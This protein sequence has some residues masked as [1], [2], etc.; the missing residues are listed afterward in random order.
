MKIKII[1]I[2]TWLTVNVICYY[3]LPNKV[4]FNNK[5]MIFTVAIKSS[6]SLV[7]YALFPSLVGWFLF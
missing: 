1:H 6:S 5:K 3:L 7:G 2:N 4:F